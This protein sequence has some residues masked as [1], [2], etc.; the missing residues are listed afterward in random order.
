MTETVVMQTD[1]DRLTER[2][3]RAAQLVQRLREEQQRLAGE[4]DQLTQRLQ[5]L[6]RKLQGQDPTTLMQE[7]TTLRRE[8]K[9]WQGE[10]RDVASRI[11][12]MRAWQE[13]HSARSRWGRMRERCTTAT[14]RV[15]S[16][17]P[18]RAVTSRESGNRRRQVVE[19]RVRAPSQW[20]PADVTKRP[21][22]TSSSRIRL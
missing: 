13:A 17:A 3:E 14:G 16:Q 2:V 21:G 1:L 18:R 22:D 5:D 7:L 9:D 4:R 10:R 15:R 11:E 19:F 8:Q 6:E 20:T 12:S